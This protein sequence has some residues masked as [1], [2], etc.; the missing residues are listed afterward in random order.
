MIIDQQRLL[1][2]F[3][4]IATAVFGALNDNLLKAAIIVFAA[5]SVP[6][7]QAATIGL[8]A[9]GLLMLPFVLFSGW[10]GILADRIEKA[11]MIRLVK[12]SELALAGGA[13]AAMMSGNIPPISAELRQIGRAHV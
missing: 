13:T 5:M 7:D 9:G 10:A 4:L 8:M 11:R 3:P 1:S 2:Y 6:A 12:W